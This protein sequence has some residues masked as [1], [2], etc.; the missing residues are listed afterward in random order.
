MTAIVD[1]Q[2]ILKA[3]GIAVYVTSQFNLTPSNVHVAI[4]TLEEGLGTKQG[5]ELQ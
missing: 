2:S 5:D 3:T 4:Q 1:I